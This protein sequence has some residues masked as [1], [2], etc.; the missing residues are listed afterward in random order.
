MPRIRMNPDDRKKQLLESALVLA[1]SYG[2]KALTRVALAAETGTTDG[3]VN[4]Y[5]GGRNGLRETV[6]CEGVARKNK[7][8]V[9]WALRDGYVIEGAPRQLMR[10]ANALVPSLAT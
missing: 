9:A 10:D 2:I 4:R 3:L 5:F 7:R 6:I 1:D 8:I